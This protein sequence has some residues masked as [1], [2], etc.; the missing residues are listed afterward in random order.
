M[1]TLYGRGLERE[2]IE[3]YGGERVSLANG[4]YDTCDIRVPSKTSGAETS[5]MPIRI[6]IG[7][8]SW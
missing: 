8:I 2:L 6:D 1:D 7:N 4:F 3:A 5:Q